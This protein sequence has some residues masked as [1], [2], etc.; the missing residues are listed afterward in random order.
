MMN[1]GFH[2]LFKFLIYMYAWYNKIIQSVIDIIGFQ[3]KQV[4]NYI[5]V[6]IKQSLKLNAEILNSK[7]KRENKQQQQ[8]IL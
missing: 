4:K 1:T 6:F 7:T 8:Q 3:H 2:F 5:P